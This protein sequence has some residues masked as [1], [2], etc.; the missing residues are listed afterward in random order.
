VRGSTALIAAEE[1]PQLVAVPACAQL[2]PVQRVLH[3]RGCIG[4]RAPIGLQAGHISV[5]GRLD[6]I[7]CHSRGTTRFAVRPAKAEPCLGGMLG[8]RA[9]PQCILRHGGHRILV[10]AGGAH[11]RIKAV[12]EPCVQAAAIGAWGVCGHP[13]V[14]AVGGM[15]PLEPLRAVRARRQ[16][17]L[18]HGAVKHKSHGSGSVCREE[19]QCELQGAEVV[20]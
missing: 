18:L 6:P 4:G 15:A 16:T 8:S 19:V 17:P 11:N 3:R 20:A 2:P 7:R 5:L 13:T 12:A 10:Q 14:E 1:S 9:P